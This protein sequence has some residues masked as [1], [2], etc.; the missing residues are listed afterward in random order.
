[1]PRQRRQAGPANIPGRGGTRPARRHSSPCRCA[2]GRPRAGSMK[3]PEATSGPVTVRVNLTGR[4]RSNV[5]IFTT[6]QPILTDVA[7][8]ASEGDRQNLIAKVP[9]DL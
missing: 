7:N 9:A 8:L 2:V 5:V 6:D 1:M 3:V 4:S